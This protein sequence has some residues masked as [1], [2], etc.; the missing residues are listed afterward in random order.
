MIFRIVLIADECKEK[1]GFSRELLERCLG[2]RE[3][4]VY[5]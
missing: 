2:K 3:Y 1:E 4:G 5:D